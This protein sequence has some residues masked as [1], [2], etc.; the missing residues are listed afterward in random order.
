MNQ[1][2]LLKEAG[3]TEYESKI[4]VALA[5]LSTAKASE[6]AKRSGVPQNK[7]YECLI[8][9]AEKGFVST[10]NFTPRQYKITGIQKFKDI[11]EEKEKEVKDLKKGI[12]N[13][14]KDFAKH[15]FDVKDSALVL[16]GKN[17]IM[18]MLHQ[19]TPK[20]EKFQYTFGGR[21]QF[22]YKSARMIK[23]ALK[24]G[25]EFR[26]LIHKSEKRKEDIKKWKKVGVKIRYYPKDEQQSIRFSSI[27]GKI[28]RVTIGSPEVLK[29]EN[30]ISFWVESIA[31]ASLMKDQFLE[32]WEKG[33]E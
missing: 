24:R 9:L 14:E 20:I 29:H 30:Y 3:F 2:Q 7:V 32:M 19:T 22:D 6:I 21:F 4:Y 26:F 5:Q 33:K 17:Q 11:L 1:K 16:K 28:C 8:K 25:V 15:T 31:F 27:D 12:D 18:Q 23:E 13:L 10:L